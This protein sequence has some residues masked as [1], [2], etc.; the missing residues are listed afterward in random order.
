MIKKMNG[1]YFRIEWMLDKLQL[2]AFHV[3]EETQSY[4]LLESIITMMFSTIKGPVVGA[5]A[6]KH[7][8]RYTCI[9]KSPT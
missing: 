8:K 2:A 4:F 1:E 3:V 9:W 5:N 6:E 7:I